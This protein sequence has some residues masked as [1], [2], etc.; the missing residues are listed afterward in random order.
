M[1]TIGRL[2]VQNPAGLALVSGIFFAAYLLVRTRTLVTRPNAFLWIAL[3]WA[4]WAIWELAILRFTPEADIRVDLLL[5]IP[6]ALIVSIAG[7]IMAFW[8]NR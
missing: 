6:A 3:V 5:I 7:L 1:E 4:L 8:R 2:F